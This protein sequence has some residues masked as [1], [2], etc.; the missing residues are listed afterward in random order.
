ME[1]FQFK[2]WSPFLGHAVVDAK[3][4][5]TDGWFSRSQERV[6]LVRVSTAGSGI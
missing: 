5:Q 1:L 3:H 6:Y 2:T 4:S